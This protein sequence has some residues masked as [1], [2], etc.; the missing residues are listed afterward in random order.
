[1]ELNRINKILDRVKEIP[2][3]M[4]IYL[5][6]SCAKNEEKPISDIDLAVIVDRPSKKIEA[7]IVS[8]ASKNL[9]IVLFHRLPLHIKYEVLKYGREL[10][11][12]DEDFMANIRLNVV[13]DYLEFSHIYKHIKA[14]VLK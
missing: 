7:D 5:F 3:V 11:V 10:Y 4:A 8:L 6:G 13:K 14:E 1:M 12:K 9:D 2:E